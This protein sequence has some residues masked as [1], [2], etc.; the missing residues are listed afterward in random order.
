MLAD[1]IVKE[2]TKG[3]TMVKIAENTKLSVRYDYK[4]TGFT[5]SDS[6]GVTKPW[7]EW[8]THT[9]EPMPY[10]GAA[11]FANALS[12]LSFVSMPLFRN[13]VTIPTETNETA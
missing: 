7:V 1:Y 3:N 9:T 8:R 13:V 11:V 5:A 10:D 2:L 6:D 4:V 12:D